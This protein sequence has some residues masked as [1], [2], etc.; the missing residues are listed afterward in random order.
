MRVKDLL[1]NKILNQRINGDGYWQVSMR[2]NGKR[3]NK[4]PHKLFADAFMKNPENK[5]AINHKNL[6]KTDNIPCNIEWNTP[7]E[8]TLHAHAHGAMPV[9]EAVR[10]AK[11]NASQVLEIYHA[12]E[13]HKKLARKYNVTYRAI[14]KIKHKISWTSVL[15]DL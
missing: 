5:A 2:K 8:N 14:A 6:I 1:R 11:L 4:R 3:Q 9:G 12:N 15:K 7:A 13:S 10:H